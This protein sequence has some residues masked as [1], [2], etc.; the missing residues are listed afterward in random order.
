MGLLD[1]LGRYFSRHPEALTKTV[2]ALERWA[3]RPGAEPSPGRTKPD[4]TGANPSSEDRSY[5]SEPSNRPSGGRPRA[6]F[7]LSEARRRLREG[8]SKRSIA[9][10]LGLSPRTLRRYLQ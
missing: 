6:S 4:T 10:S 3:T 5:P 9:Q 7:S 8:E 2:D 1:A